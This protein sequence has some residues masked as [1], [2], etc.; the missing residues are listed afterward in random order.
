MSKTSNT[1]ANPFFVQ[2]I[3]PDEYFCDRKED[4]DRII[5]M[6]RDGNNIVLTS[7]RRIGKSSL[8]HHILLQKEIRRTYN[9]LYVDIQNTQSA[10]DF[11]MAMKKALRDPATSTFPDAFRGE[12]ETVTRE[13]GIHSGF[14]A[15]PVSLQADYRERQQRKDEDVLVEVFRLLGR[16]AKPNLVIFDEFQQIE[17]YPDNI[18]A[19]LRAN[20]QLLSNS[21]FIYSGSSVHMLASMFTQYNHP[22]YNSSM[23]YGLKRIP[24]QVYA[25]FCREMFRKRGRMI[26]G[27]ACSLIYD[28]F[29]GNTLNMQQ[30][31]NRVFQD[32]AVGDTADRQEAEE[33][34]RTILQDR[35]DLYEAA[36]SS[37][38]ST[39]ER[40]VVACIANEGVAEG[41]TSTTMLAR[42]GLGAP[43]SVSNHLKA[44]SGEERKV[45]TRTGNTWRLAD[46]FFELWILWQAG[47]LTA[48]F[49]EAQAVRLRYERARRAA[50]PTKTVLRETQPEATTTKKRG[51]KP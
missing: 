24:S 11:I 38:K 43:S 22:F 46:R 18:T 3:I 31:M 20:I 33:A 27:E 12:F 1:P 15:G 39:G 48:R 51:P 50:L 29:L 44:L 5:T 7:P 49:E 30:V 42:Y 28:L 26:T 32:T 47:T 35:S 6:L 13:Y 14:T 21:R 25:D 2:T 17:K 40:R 37:L 16:T 4:T 10:A 45:I 9:T 8:L 36:F 41:M 23:P 34:I 19:L